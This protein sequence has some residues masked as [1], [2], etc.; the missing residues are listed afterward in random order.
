MGCPITKHYSDNH[1]KTKNGFEFTPSGDNDKKIVMEATV[2]PYRTNEVIRDAKVLKQY[3]VK[4]LIGNGTFSNVFRV[5]NK[6]SKLPYAIKVIGLRSLKDRE[7][8]E[9]EKSVL[10]NVEHPNIV[11]FQEVITSKFHAFIVME[12][13]TGGDLFERIHTLGHIDE[14][15]TVRVSRMLVDAIHYLHQNNI[16]HRD[17]KPENILYYCPG[18]NSRIILTDFGFASYRISDAKMLSTYCGTMNYLSPEIISGEN[19]TNKV[20]IWSL[21]VIIYFMLGGYLPFT[22]NDVGKLQEKILTAPHLYQK[23]VSFNL[24]KI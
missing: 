3:D 9:A 13:A 5:E 2:T 1:S 12:L 10:M 24:K 20:D 21:G 18:E 19:Y 14:T 16:T 7:L 11:K 6:S 8:F 15:E 17:L 22:C 23:W 4:Q